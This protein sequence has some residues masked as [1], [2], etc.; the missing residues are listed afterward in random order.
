MQKVKVCHIVSGYF[1]NDPRILYR[2]CISLHEEGYSVSILTNDGLPDE[3]IEGISIFSTRVYWK[4]RLKILL[5]AKKQF[6]SRA[7]EI[8]ADIYQI[9]SPEL[10]SLGLYLK[11]VG[12]LVVYD[13]HEDLPAHILEKDWLPAILR[14]PISFAVK[15][16]MN[17]VLKRFDA[18]VTPHPHVLEKMIKVNYNSKL[19]T[20]FAKVTEVIPYSLN[21]YIN[22]GKKIC[23]SGTVYLHSNQLTILDSLNQ[24]P[25]LIYIVAGYFS[26]E[27]LKTLS[28]HQSFKNLQY[29]GRLNKNDLQN[30]YQEARIGVVIIDYKMNLG[31]QKGTYAVNKMFEYMEASLPII[32]SDYDLWREIVEEYQCGICVQ[33]GNTKQ[34]VEALKFLLNNPSIAYEMG[35]RG[36]KAVEEKYNWSSQHLTYVNIFDSLKSK[37]INQ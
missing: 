22:R 25:D 37:S 19:V 35:Q 32:C 24:I 1:R 10:L 5:F 2:Q 27:H 15:F 26:P 21:D 17:I 13:A 36:R 12:K 31:G 11:K 29:F 34:L 30:F 20:N 8:N 16:Y 9:H 23:Y 33:P 28:S 7:N 4:S 6:I 18:I 3:V 14:K